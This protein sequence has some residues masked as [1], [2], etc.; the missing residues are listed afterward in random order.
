MTSKARGRASGKL[1]GAV[2][3]L[4]CAG[5]G[6]L[7]S[8]LLLAG[9]LL[10]LPSLIVGL[11]ER[12]RGHPVARAMALF[13]LSVSLPAIIRLWEMGGGPNAGMALATDPVFVARAWAAAGCGWLLTETVPAALSLSANNAANREL[14]RLRALRADLEAEWSFPPADP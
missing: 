3:L 7:A 12:G 6:V 11:S 9:G 4:A 13:T 10:L 2:L 8:G 1:A 5:L 14:Q